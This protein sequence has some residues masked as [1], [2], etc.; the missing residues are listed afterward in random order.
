MFKPTIYD[1]DNIVLSFDSIFWTVGVEQII[2]SVHNGATRIITTTPPDLELLL[3]LISK[4]RVTILYCTPFVLIVCLKSDVIH[5]PDLSS[6]KTIYMC[7]TKVPNDLITEIGRYFPNAKCV[8]W[9]GLSELGRMFI[10][11]HNANGKPNGGR[12]LDGFLAKIVDVNGNLCGPNESGELCIKK[13]YK[14]HGYLDDSA[15]NAVAIDSEGF[16]QTG[17]I[18]RFD[19]HEHFFIE[20]RIKNVISVYFF[21]GVILPSQIEEFL[22]A[23]PDIKDV[24]VVGIPIVSGEALPAALILRATHSNLNES[25]V[26]NLVAGI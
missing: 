22:I 15:A 10:F 1:A 24:C 16:F 23:I 7:G 12:L 13:K 19:E 18:C 17:D 20:D 9:Y 25:D 3:Q 8:S 26:Y 2:D 11:S 6:V 4:Y 21:E 14:F 5:K